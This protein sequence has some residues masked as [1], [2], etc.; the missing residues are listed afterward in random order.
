MLVE[1]YRSRSI[2]LQ[3]YTMLY[4]N[5]LRSAS[6]SVVRKVTCRGPAHECT[7]C[8]PRESCLVYRFTAHRSPLS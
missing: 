7:G 3:E 5:M 1:L 6:H 2:V 4:L 8:G